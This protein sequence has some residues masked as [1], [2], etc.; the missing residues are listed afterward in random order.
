MPG[1]RGRHGEAAV[2][3][4][5]VCSIGHKRGALLCVYPP[6]ILCTHVMMWRKERSAL[7]TG[8]PGALQELLGPDATRADF[9]RSAMAGTI[10][11]TCLIV[12][13]VRN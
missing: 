8:G 11:G 4:A 1:V 10:A 7:T 13:E 12:K 3:Q 9:Q 2:S 6:F 5:G